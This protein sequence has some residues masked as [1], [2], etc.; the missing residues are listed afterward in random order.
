VAT[1]E[2]VVPASTLRTPDGGPP[3]TSPESIVVPA[4][5]GASR[6][7]WWD[8]TVRALAGRGAV[9][10]MAR[11][12]ALQAQCV[13][14][15][16]GPN[17]RRLVLQVERD[18]LRQPGQIERL[19]AAL[20]AHLGSATA[21]EVEA[22]PVSDSPAMREARRAERRQQEAEALIHND[23]VVRALLTEFRSARIVPGSI[24]P[25]PN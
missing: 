22:G 2:L 4:L 7:D 5:H 23:P 6:D 15:E 3:A 17:G 19:R 14:D 10:A 25:I 18:S 12:L 8:D 24:K 16:S 1:P 13:R 11:E 9:Q 21:L 20:E